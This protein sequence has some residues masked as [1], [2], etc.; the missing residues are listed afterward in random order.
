[1]A[2]TCFVPVSLPRP[3]L[4]PWN[5]CR[6]ML[7][8][9][10]RAQELTPSTRA[11]EEDVKGMRE[12]ESGISYQPLNQRSVHRSQSDRFGGKMAGS[13]Y[14]LWACHLEARP[15]LDSLHDFP[16]GNSSAAINCSRRRIPCMFP[17]IT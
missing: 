14:D 9:R 7:E 2:S 4:L 13:A 16:G 1:M 3:L 11:E 12:G 5:S 6:S 10:R 8:E 15:T 17:A